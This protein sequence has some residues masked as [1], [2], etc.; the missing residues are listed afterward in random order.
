MT[1]TVVDACVVAADCQDRGQCV[2]SKCVC[3]PGF[4]PPVCDPFCV[5]PQNCSNHGHCV[6][7]AC[8]CSAGWSGPRCAS[9]A[10]NITCA[11]GGVPNAPNATCTHCVDC[12]FGWEGPT[13]AAWN[14]AALP[15]LVAH[16]QS[17]AN[18]SRAAL[19]ALAPLHPLPGSVG[20]GANIVTGALASLPVVKLT[21]TDKPVEVLRNT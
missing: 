3:N 17:L 9:A 7:D 20:W 2:D 14:P 18:G 21:Y 15:S 19:A 13:C 5:G 10:C 8:S 1:V 6:N 12:A 4:V 11:H 16:L